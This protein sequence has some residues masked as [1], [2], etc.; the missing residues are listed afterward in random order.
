MTVEPYI[1][2]GSIGPAHAK[3]MIVG[4]APGETEVMQKTPFVGD[5]GVLFKAMMAE[6]G[7]VW[8]N[9]YVTNLVKFQPPRNN[10]DHL[11]EDRSK[12]KK[13]TPELQVAVQYLAKEIE[14][15]NPNIIIAAGAEPLK[16]LTACSP[17]TKFAGSLL[18]CTLVPGYKVLPIIHPSALNRGSWMP[19]RVV[20]PV[21]LR[22]AYDHS[23]EK[24][25]KL[26]VR[27]F[28]YG[29]SFDEYVAELQRLANADKVCVDIETD[30]DNNLT[31]IG[32]TDSANY[33]V[34]V[35][36]T[37]GLSSYFTE[38]EESYLFTLIADILEDPDIIK[39]A[40]NGYFDMM[41]LA[42]QHGII[43]QGPLVDSM[44]MHHEIYAEM[45]KGLD[46]LTGLYTDEPYFKFERKLEGD[47][48]KWIY[49][50]KDVAI[51]FEIAEVLEEELKEA[52]LWEN[53]LETVSF[54]TPLMT[55]GLQ[56]VNFD[57]A[58][59]RILSQ[60]Y[61]KIVMEKERE[62]MDIIG[63]PVNVNSPKQ[64][65]TILYEELGLP[66]QYDGQGN[67][68]SLTTNLKALLKL[69]RKAKEKHQRVLDLIIDIRRAR[70]MNSTYLKPTDKTGMKVDSLDRRMRCDYNVAGT[71]TF[72]LSSSESLFGCGTNLQNIPKRRDK[73]GGVR[74]LFIADDG[75]AI[76]AIDLSQAEARVVS[77]LCG[78]EP[79]IRA[80]AK[81]LDV[82]SEY[83]FSI[84]N[85]LEGISREDFFSLPPKKFKE[86]RN[87]GKQVKHA[88]NYDAT[89]AT[90][91]D[92][93]MTEMEM[94]LLAAEAKRLLEAGR[95]ANPMLE[96]W[97]RSIR[98]SLDNKQPL[99]TPFGKVR[100]FG[101]KRGIPKTYKEA[102]AFIPQST[103]GHL[104]L[105]GLL[106]IYEELGDEVDLLLQVH[107]EVVVQYPE[108]KPEFV[109]RA[110]E[111][112][113]EDIPI[114][115]RVLRIPAELSVGYRWGSL[116]EF[117]TVP[118][119]EEI[120]EA[121]YEQK[122]S[123]EAVY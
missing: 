71:N 57:Q 115:G 52:G 35:P 54:I 27:E 94:Y 74:N 18:P 28:V 114:N 83:A 44:Y 38:E 21:H 67:K 90:L 73:S 107:D 1:Q 78:D 42:R 113:E 46:F 103:V 22:R 116:H 109:L 30:R 39:I 72:R 88:T 106:R 122:S 10:F 123:R 60:Q 119:I 59:Q 68:R 55:M 97:H 69:R 56:G 2:V 80:Y 120:T 92:S 48:A 29:R 34:C 37:K 3:I 51:T 41:M 20:T 31:C 19:W 110:R 84:A 62:L 112:M 25:L 100:W 15:V 66:K 96:G 117:K 98:H 26:P 8:D 65:A 36:L 104:T 40:Q 11:Y 86:W 108:D 7:V 87:L 47:E 33:A 53:Y 76:G 64:M 81:G 50:C 63:H 17:I 121:L 32:F 13:P 89:W 49:N 91:M 111:L 14:T 16:W 5:A 102:Y 23:G 4:E 70:K 95:E 12:R 105:R 101:G 93:C 85:A 61:G 58:G 24:D 45:P 99:T 82:H 77:Y 79:T 43:F 6:A 9:C 75:Y 118:T